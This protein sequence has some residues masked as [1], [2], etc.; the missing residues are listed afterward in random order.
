MARNVE[1]KARVPGLDA[2]RE[3]ARSRASSAAEFLEQTDTFFEAPRGRLKVREFADGTGELISYQRSDDRGPKE[4]VYS[5]YPCQN[6]KALSK[7]LSKVLTVRGV[8]VKRREVIMLGRTRVHLDK[9][10]GLGSFVELEVVLHDDESVESGRLEADEL[11]R[12]L[13]IPPHALIAEAHIDLLEGTILAR[14]DKVA[15]V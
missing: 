2:I 13:D 11:L 8:V 15:S 9:V 1:I 10:E 4:S 6:A 14:A 5:R 7:T 3:K 12:V